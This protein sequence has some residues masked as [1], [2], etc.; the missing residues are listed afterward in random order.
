ML[1]GATEIK[2]EKEK[3]SNVYVV[4][5]TGAGKTRWYTIP[6]VKQEEKNIIVVESRKKEIYYATNQTKAEQGYE[7]LQLDLLHPLFEERLQD[8]V[9]NATQQKFVLYIS[10]NLID[11]T[12]QE[13]GDCLQKVFDLLQEK[14]LE[15]DVHLYLD[16]YELYPIPNLLHVLQVVKAKGIHI[17]MIVQSHAH[18]Q[19]VY[20]KQFANQIAGDC[21]QILFFGTNSMDDAKYFSRMSGYNQMELFLL[22]NEVIVLDTY[23]LPRKIPIKQVDCNH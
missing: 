2:F 15:R 9:V 10:V 3:H 19:Q 11:S 18:L 5:P 7:I 6:N 4:G 16:E 1:I 13:R 20:G 12:Y 17:S 21:N 22:Q 23:Y 8:M 14:T